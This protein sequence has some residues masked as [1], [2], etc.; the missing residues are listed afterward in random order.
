MNW[1]AI[2]VNLAAAMVAPWTTAPSASSILQLAGA[3]YPAAN[4]V[5]T[6]AAAF[7]GRPPILPAYAPV[8]STFQELHPLPWPFVPPRLAG[9]IQTD[10]FRY[11][12]P[13]RTGFPVLGL[14]HRHR[15]LHRLC[16]RRQL[17]SA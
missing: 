3:T 7:G 15:R 14:L 16:F 11:P 5:Q 9:Q 2:V 4:V 10:S 13:N 6:I 1:I 17:G 12:V 8:A